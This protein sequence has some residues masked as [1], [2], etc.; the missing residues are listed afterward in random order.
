MDLIRNAL[1]AIKNL[2]VWLPDSVVT[3]IILALAGVIAYSL[4]KWVRKLLR[5]ALAERNPYVLSMFSQMRGVTQLGLIILANLATS[6][7]SPPLTSWCGCGI[8][9]S[10]VRPSRCRRLPG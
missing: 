10:L 4:H 6:K 5:H 9:F 7:R 2:L 8:A 1:T 3:I